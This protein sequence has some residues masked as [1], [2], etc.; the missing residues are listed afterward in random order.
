MFAIPSSDAW[1]KEG[2]GHKVRIFAF[3]GALAVHLFVGWSL[4]QIAL[5]PDKL[6]EI[7]IEVTLISAASLKAPVAAQKQELKSVPIPPKQSVP[8]DTP[9]KVSPKEAEAEKPKEPT[10]TT[11]SKKAKVS[12]ERTE[13]GDKNSAV[14]E[15]RF[16]V[17]NLHN[18]PPAYPT[19]ARRLGQEGTVQLRVMVLA[20]GVAGSI[21]I[22]HSSGFSLLDEAAVDAVKHWHFIPAYKGRNA[23]DYQI[24]VPINF[25][26]RAH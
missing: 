18:Q 3:L 13:E 12:A 9:I 7:P 21:E 16:Q 8:A 23:V 14:T 5:K 2:E 15:P 25:T 1:T 20:I 19:S 26:L 24:I 10:V 4:T 22:L 17:E 11:P 6:P